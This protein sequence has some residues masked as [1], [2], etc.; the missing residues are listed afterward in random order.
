MAKPSLFVLDTCVLVSDPKSFETFPESEVVIPITVLDELDHL[1]TQGSVAGKNARAAIR[2]LDQICSQGDISQGIKLPNG[3][4]LSVDTSAYPELQMESKV[5]EMDNRILACA[6]QIKKNRKKVDVILVSEDINMRVR[7]QAFGLKVQGYSKKDQTT[8]DLYSGLIEL[9]DEDAGIILNEINW[10]DAK[11]FK[12]IND[13]SP[14]QC[15]HLSDESGRGLC[16]ARKIG[17]KLKKI[18]TEKK[19]WGLEAK[20]KEQA[21][22]F[23]LICDPKINL[24]TSIGSAGTGKSLCALACGLELVLDKKQYNK[25]IIYKSTDPVGRELGFLPGGLEDKIK[26]NFL[27]VMDS[28]EYLFSNG[29]KN[30]RWEDSLDLYI[31][32]GLIQMEPVTFLR[33]RSINNA[34]II[35]DECQNFSTNNELRTLLTRVGHDTKCILLGDIQQVDNKNNDAINNG[36]TQVIEA[37]KESSLAGH[38]SLFKCE[39]SKLAEESCKLL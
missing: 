18:T 9:V 23:D 5:P 35:V 30:Q 27:S 17:N 25:L 11:D 33:G 4:L 10:I 21:V 37:F 39:R 16:L 12:W 15:V 22:L 1:K 3:T 2:N 7:G 19:P 14:N 38:I 32:K 34:L 28:F 20:S 6:I 8:E 31:Q 29:R 24:V 26:F 36:L 13:L